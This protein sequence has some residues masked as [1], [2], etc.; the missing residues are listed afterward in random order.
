MSEWWDVGA[1]NPCSHLIQQQREPLFLFSPS[2]NKGHTSSIDAGYWQW[3]IMVYV[4]EF[5]LLKDERK[6]GSSTE[7]KEKAARGNVKRG[8]GRPDVHGKLFTN[9][10][11]HSRTPEKY[12][13]GLWI[14][15]STPD[16]NIHLHLS[17]LSLMY[18]WVCPLSSDNLLCSSV[19]RDFCLISSKLKTTMR[20]RCTVAASGRRQRQTVNISCLQRF[21][22]HKELGTT[23]SSVWWSSQVV[24]SQLDETLRIKRTES[25][26]S[27]LSVGS[28]SSERIGDPFGPQ[29]KV[30]RKSLWFCVPSTREPPQMLTKIWWIYL[31]VLHINYKYAVMYAI[32]K[33]SP[34]HVYPTSSTI[35]GLGF[36]LCKRDLDSDLTLL[37]D[38]TWL[39]LDLM[40]KH[41]ASCFDKV[42]FWNKAILSYMSYTAWIINHWAVLHCSI[43]TA[44]KG[45]YWKTIS[46]D[47]HYLIF[48]NCI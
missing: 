20:P 1:C 44:L 31:F 40:A 17:T 24:R 27:L 28:H 26:L 41:Q 37:G 39:C 13:G 2:P 5:H 11:H 10:E 16:N 23:W 18:K 14:T 9:T 4:M 43:N 6:G 19:W 30:E 47:G 38:L 29:R 42:K 33:A 48:I 36:S 35:K 34:K 7:I 25:T 32:C 46:F 3:K 15:A 12:L 22:A 45:K 8:Q 21:T